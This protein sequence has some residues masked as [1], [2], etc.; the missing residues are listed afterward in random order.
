MSPYISIYQ[1]LIEDINNDKTDFHIL[2]A[3][4]KIQN[5]SIVLLD[6]IFSN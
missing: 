6:L 4:D 1:F 5:S 3:S 2:K